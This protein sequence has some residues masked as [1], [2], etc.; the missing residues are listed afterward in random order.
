MNT[1]MHEESK[2][3]RSCKIVEN[4]MFENNETTKWKS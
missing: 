2:V 3:N 4:K 1:G